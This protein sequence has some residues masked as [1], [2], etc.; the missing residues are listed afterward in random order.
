MQSHSFLQF[1]RSLSTGLALVVLLGVAPSALKAQTLKGREFIGPIHVGPGEIF[2]VLLSN[3]LS[4]QTAQVGVKVADGEGRIVRQIGYGKDV[5]LPVKIAPGETTTVEIQGDTPGFPVGAYTVI[6]ELFSSKEGSHAPLLSA[7][8]IGRD[9]LAG[10]WGTNGTALTAIWG[11]NGTA[12]TGIWGTG[13]VA[14]TGIWGTNGT[15]IEDTVGAFGAVRVGAEQ[16]Y[17]LLAQNPYDKDIAI[18]MIALDAHTGETLKV[19]EDLLVRGETARLNVAPGATDV[20]GV[21]QVVG[22]SASDVGPLTTMQLLDAEG[23][24]TGVWGTN[25]VA[26]EADDLQ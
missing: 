14:R 17:Q 26:Y 21:V 15:A 18:K 19:E 16:S 12:R 8:L 20:I 1:A 13:G 11:T 24:L 4:R 3:P 25:G 9:G 7:Q 22:A 23:Q 2:Q 6:A 5:P 10:I